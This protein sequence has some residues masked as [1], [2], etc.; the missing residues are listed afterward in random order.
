MTKGPLRILKETVTLIVYR[1]TKPSKIQH[2]N[3]DFMKFTKMYYLI[4][5]SPNA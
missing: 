2:F 3:A 4:T 1:S 5:L